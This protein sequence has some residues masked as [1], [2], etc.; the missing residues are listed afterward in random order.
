MTLPLPETP[1]LAENVVHFG[2]ALRQAGLSVGSGQILQAAQAVQVAGFTSRA[3]FYATL[4]ACLVTRPEDRTTFAQCFRLFWRDPRYLEQ[5]MSMLLP[6]VRGA[7]PPATPKPG[8]RRAAEA[9]TD[10]PQAAQADP[11]DAMVQIDAARTMS[12]QERLRQMDFDQMS[13]EDARAA[14]RLLTQIALPAPKILTRRYDPGRGARPDPRRALRQ[15]ARQG[16]VIGRLPTRLRRGRAPDLVVLCDISGSMASYSRAVLLFT[17]GVMTRRG[18]GWGRVHAFTFGTQLTNITP[19]MRR[20]DADTALAGAGT[21]ARDWEGGTRIGDCLTRFNR[22]W[23]RRVVSPGATVLLIT[24]GLE[25][26]DPDALARATERLS[27]SCRRLVWVNP[28][29]RFGDFAP[30]ARGVQAMLPH[31]HAVVAGHNISSLAGVA[32]A[33]R[34]AADPTQN[35]LLAMMRTDR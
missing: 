23:L 33:L 24:D 11:S 12:D 14:R 25:R 16:G 30:K 2:R 29:L 15:M 4:Q 5:M 1:K 26:S 10:G 19:Q 7:V 3:D 20:R 27:L 6:S 8:E 13:A 32:Q 18:T 22:D 9:L 17:H 35:R 28:L 34:D 21:Q 31:V